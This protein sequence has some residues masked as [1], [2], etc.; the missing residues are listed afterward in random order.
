MSAISS[1]GFQ[2]MPIQQAPPAA[3]PGDRDRD[4]DNNAPDSGSGIAQA[5]A[6]SG[7]QRALNVMA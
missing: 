3:K 1:V 5:P 7:A 2:P 4:Q 6:P